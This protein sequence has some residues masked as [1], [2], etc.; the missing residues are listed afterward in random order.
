MA[1][2]TLLS[3]QVQNR[4]GFVVSVE[5]TIRLAEFESLRVALSESFPEG[6]DHE[7]AYKLIHEQVEQWATAAKPKETL[8][9]VENHAVSPRPA[10]SKPPSLTVETR[11][12]E[13]PLWQLARSKPPSVTV[14]TLRER[15]AKST[16]SNSLDQ[17]YKALTTRGVT[18]LGEGWLD[19]VEVTSTLN[20]F[21]VKPRHF[22]LR[23]TWQA[24]DD[25][26]RTIG[27][28]WIPQAKG[29]GSW[30]VPA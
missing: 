6:M 7:Q 10:V 28:K 15:L 12:V 16:V 29:V 25:A 5:R 14:E 9:V 26:L 27:A 3:S 21:A 11:P 18:P 8:P 17:K 23:E 24:I 13:V 19:K 22:L 1:Q 30:I 4:K 2:S 20:G